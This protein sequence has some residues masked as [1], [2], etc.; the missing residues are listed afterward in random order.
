MFPPKV[1][2]LCCKKTLTT[3]VYRRKLGP[4]VHSSHNESPTLL[5][6]TLRAVIVITQHVTLKERRL[7]EVVANVK[8]NTL[9]HFTHIKEELTIAHY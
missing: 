4:L 6:P 1:C 8:L 3:I 2:F 7:V 5:S 9:S